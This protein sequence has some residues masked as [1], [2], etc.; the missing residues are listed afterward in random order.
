M[1]TSSTELDRPQDWH[2]VSQR[3]RI[4]AAS[5]SLLLTLLLIKI[6]AYVASHAE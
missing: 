5:L 1:K 4:L 6:L 3:Q 2:I